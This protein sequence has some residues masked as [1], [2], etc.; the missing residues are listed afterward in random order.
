MAC[1]AARVPVVPRG[2]GTGY[3]GGAVPTRGGVVLA[4]DRFDRIVEIDEENL[5]AVVQPNVITGVLQAEV[6]RRGLFYPPD[7]ASLDRS[8]LGG[9][10]PSARAAREHSSTGRRATTCW[11]SRRCYRPATSSA[12]AGAP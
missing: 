5:L 4:M 8:A 3:S 2:A 11:A 9:T 1:S 7:P 12:P 6:E 10:S